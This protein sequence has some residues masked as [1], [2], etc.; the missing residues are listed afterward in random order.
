MSLYLHGHA[1]DLK[2]LEQSHYAEKMLAWVNDKEVTQYLFRGLFPAT[3]KA[4]K[5]EYESYE[6]SKHDVVLA[7]YNQSEEYIGVVGLHDINWVTRS[8]EFRI[9]I[10]EKKF[11]GKGLGGE[12]TQL[13][14]AYGFEFLNLN[15]IWLGVNASNKRAKESYLKTGFV[16][17]GTLRQESYR[18]GVYDDVDRMSLLR[19]EYKVVSKKWQSSETIKR[20]LQR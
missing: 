3:P 17:E 18:S 14:I 13:M 7:I 5:D 8:A 16:Q 15:K 10:G 4:L 1:I 12:A 11:W 2:S 9:L 19:N 6:S 20:L